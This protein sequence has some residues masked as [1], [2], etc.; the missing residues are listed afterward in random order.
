MVARNL[1]LEHYFICITD[2]ATGLR[3]D[4]HAI[5]L[6]E[7][8]R[9]DGEDFFCTKRLWMFSNEAGNVLGPRFVNMD[10][11]TVIVGDITPLL[12]RNEDFIIWKAPFYDPIHH[13]C[14]D[15]PY[16]YNPSLM[17]MNAGARK[18]VWEKYSAAPQYELDSAF[19]SGWIYHGD[20]DVI[21][22]L[23]APHETTWGLKDGLYAYWTHLDFGEKE[24]PANARV[25][26]FYGPADPSQKKHQEKCKWIKENWHQ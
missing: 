23:L 10:L 13:A 4:I 8:G 6:P 14:N 17:M 11:D 24:L 26:S 20:Q 7:E 22:N 2:D 12:E 19:E 15:P 18:V 3:D 25:I 21:S 9:Q 5:P 1:K 16:A